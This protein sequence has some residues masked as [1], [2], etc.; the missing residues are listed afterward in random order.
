MASWHVVFQV[1]IRPASGSDAQ[2]IAL[3]R[4]PDLDSCHDAVA[5]YAAWVATAMEGGLYLGWLAEQ[6]GQVIGGVGLMFLEWGPTRQDSH[7]W[8]A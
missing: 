2:T 8:R 6:D 7:P 1:H 5:T 4:Y 3:H